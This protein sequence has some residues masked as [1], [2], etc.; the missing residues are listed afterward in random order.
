MPSYRLELVFDT[1]ETGVVDLAA[2]A[3]RG[4]F[5]SWEK[6]GEFDRVSITHQ[7]AVEWPGEIDLCPDALYLLMTGRKAEDVFPALQNRLSHA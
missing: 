1:G 3:G 6:V 2:L 5:K 4:V 7:G